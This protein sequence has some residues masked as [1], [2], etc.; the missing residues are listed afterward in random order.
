MPSNQNL[1]FCGPSI[2]SSPP[3]LSPASRGIA[4]SKDVARLGRVRVKGPPAGQAQR[5]GGILMPKE[6]RGGAP[7]VQRGERGVPQAQRG[8]SSLDAKRRDSPSANRRKKGEGIPL[9]LRLVEQA[10]KASPLARHKGNLLPSLA[11]R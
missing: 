5:G 2:L 4:A 9:P 11:S 1:A 7:H 6:K 10:R 3:L 8:E